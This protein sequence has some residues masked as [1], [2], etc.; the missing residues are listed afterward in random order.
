[1]AGV[2]TTGS[3]LAC[4]H[5]ATATASS[6]A[7]LKVSGNSVLTSAG[8]SGWS[9]VSASCSQQ[10]VPNTPKSSYVACASMKSQNGG[11]SQKLTAGGSP[12]VLDSIKG[13]T[14][15][16]PDAGVSCQAGHTKL[17]AS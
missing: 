13:D 5:G 14:I 7:K 17:T 12:V 16:V 8:I 10:P 2:L 1:M 11:Q 4:A 15:G 9:F 3:T 6:S